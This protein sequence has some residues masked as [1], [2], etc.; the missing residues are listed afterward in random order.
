MVAI[1][2]GIVPAFKNR[3]D[4]TE[5]ASAGVVVSYDDDR[6]RMIRAHTL[7]EWNASTRV[8]E[9]N[10]FEKFGSKIDP[11]DGPIW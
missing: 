10:G 2:Y 4:A 5:A 9:K 3:V 6:V 11:E 7:P 1:A 8:L